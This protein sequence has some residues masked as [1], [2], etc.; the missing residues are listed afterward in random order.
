[1]SN[2]Q[3]D[4][5][6]TQKQKTKPWVLARKVMQA[7]SLLVF[8]LTLLFSKQATFPDSLTSG[9]VRLSP[10]AMLAEL[11]SNKHFLTGSLLSLV[12]LLSSLLV[13]RAWCGWLCPLGTVLDIFRF[14]KL[15]HQKPFP[16]NLRKFKYGLLI[17]IL[18][19]AILG[20]LTFLIFDPITIFVRSITLS[21]IPL[22]DQGIYALEKLLIKVPSISQS[23]FTFDAW[24]RPRILPVESAFFQYSLV[25][26][27]F[28]A[29]I[30]LLNVFAERFWCRY[31]CPLGALLGL[32]SRFSLFQR[33]VSA[34]CVACGL[35]AADCPTET[36]DARNGYQSDPSECT[37]CMNC[38]NTCS[39]HAISFAPKW[40]SAKKESYDPGRR[41]FLAS[42]GIAIGS[43]LLLGVD[44]I[45]NQ[46]RLFLLR[47]PGAIDNEKFLTTCVRC[48]LCIQVCPTQALQ[49]DLDLSDLEGVATPILVPRSGYCD[50]ACNTCGQNCPVEAI[51]ALSLAEKRITKIGT[52]HIDHHRCIAWGDHG[53]CIVCE[54][55]CPLPEKAIFIEKRT[56]QQAN[57][58]EVEVLLPVVDRHK[59]IGC[60]ICENKCPVE[61]ESAIRVYS[62]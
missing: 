57:G 49:A 39:V 27:F 21:I 38:A 2:S 9:L 62:S 31:L 56:F 61:G 20:N 40:L 23:V 19:S 52:A 28:F 36:I 7:I 14:P 11:F 34:D 16:Q 3:V 35:C 18:V 41:F 1:M 45:K 55:M 37:L 44:W 22:L 26:G 42:V 15:L 60:G 29:A 58:N 30:L 4:M 51:P 17:V 46:S 53:N 13:G 10:L 33:R 5:M 12:I 25:F 54:E 6:K 59:C 8:V 24:L 47:P 32:G 43:T 48:G 50:Y